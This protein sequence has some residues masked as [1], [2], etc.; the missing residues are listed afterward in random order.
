MLAEAQ[1]RAEAI[2]ATTGFQRQV[3]AI[4]S[5]LL[6]MRE[7]TSTDINELLEENDHG[8]DN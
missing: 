6:A 7:L 3:E 2:A 5:A 8:Q 4:A 1:E